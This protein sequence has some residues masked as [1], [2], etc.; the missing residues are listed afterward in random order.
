MHSF[1]HQWFTVLVLVSAVLSSASVLAAEIDSAAVRTAMSEE[2]RL[3]DDLARDSRS[4]PEVVIPLLHIEAGATVVDIFGSGGYYSE[5]LAS[6]VGAEGEVWL[7]NNDGFEA[8]GINGLRDRFDKRDLG[9]INRHTRSGINLDLG[10]ETMDAAII[11][12]A[13]HDIYVIPKRYNG[14]EYVPVGSPANATYFLEQIYTAL[15]PGSRFIVVEHAGD[16]SME[17]EEVFDLHRMIEVRA[18]NE[19]ENVG[20]H[21]IESSD[22]LRNPKDDRSMIVFD[23]DIKGQTDRF[24]LSFE[25]PSN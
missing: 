7:H 12:M 14:E 16:A 22:A 1:L 3:P 4:K 19:V 15:K 24:V 5:L 2:G 11:V 6:V 17:S 9:N 23:S 20:F 10:E 13:L 18:R 8:W 25:K 21:F